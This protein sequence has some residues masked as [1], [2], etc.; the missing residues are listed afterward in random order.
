MSAIAAR[1]ARA[2]LD[3]R[4]WQARA[5]RLALAAVVII[6]AGT[7]VALGLAS[8]GRGQGRASGTDKTVIWLVALVVVLVIVA[9]LAVRKIRIIQMYRVELA[10]KLA[11]EDAPAGGPALPEAGP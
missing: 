9:P 6:F 1:Y 4:P 10:N 2:Y 11:L 3:L 7:G 8:P 5:Q